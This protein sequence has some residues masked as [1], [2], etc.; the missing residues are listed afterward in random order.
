MSEQTLLQINRI[1]N[2]HEILCSIRS[3]SLNNHYLYNSPYLTRIVFSV[4]DESVTEMELG[5]NTSKE[6]LFGLQRSGLQTGD[7]VTVTWFSSN[8]YSD[9]STITVNLE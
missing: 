7:R 5:Q 2:T 4:N 9:H 6:G 8:G 3:A 1:G